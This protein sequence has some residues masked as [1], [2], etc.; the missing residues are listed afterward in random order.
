[1]ANQKVSLLPALFAVLKESSLGIDPG[2]NCSVAEASF[3]QAFRPEY[4]LPTWLDLLNSCLLQR[5]RVVE[6]DFDRRTGARKC[7]EQMAAPNAPKQARSVTLRVTVKP[8]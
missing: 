8:F 5:P 6:G 4:F 1:M 2:L 7:M 3:N